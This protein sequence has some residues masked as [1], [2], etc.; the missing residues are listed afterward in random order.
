MVYFTIMFQDC[1][2]AKMREHVNF[3]TDLEKWGLTGLQRASNRSA[4]W[5]RFRTSLGV[6]KEG[7]LYAYYRRK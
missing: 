7:N 5:I 4:L 1:C 6:L 2:G 3:M